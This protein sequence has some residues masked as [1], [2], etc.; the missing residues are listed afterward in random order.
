MWI[1]IQSI[2]LMIRVVIVKSEFSSTKAVE[3]FGGFGKIK[4][5]SS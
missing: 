2:L 5:P 4:Y 3:G 1:W